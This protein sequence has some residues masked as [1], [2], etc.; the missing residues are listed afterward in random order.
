MSFEEIIVEVIK[1][2]VIT[3]LGLLFSLGNKNLSKRT[4]EFQQKFNTEHN[5]RIM[6]KLSGTALTAL[7][8]M[9]LIWIFISII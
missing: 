9:G 4:R 3:G 5:L 1:G 7:I 8:I 2:I 6:Y